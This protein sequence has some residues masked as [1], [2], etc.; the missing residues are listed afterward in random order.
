MKNELAKINRKADA[1]FRNNGLR[2][3]QVIFD[4]DHILQEFHCSHFHPRFRMQIYTELQRQ[5]RVVE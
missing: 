1:V 3:F 4:S 5:T 2:A